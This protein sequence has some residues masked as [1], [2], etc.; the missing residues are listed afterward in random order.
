EG[1]SPAVRSRC[2]DNPRQ[3]HWLEITRRLDTSEID[4]LPPKVRD[5][6]CDL[7]FGILAISAEEHIRWAAGKVRAKHACVADGVEGF[8]HVSARQKPLNL[9]TARV[10]V[11][12]GELRRKSAAAI[13]WVGRVDDDLVP[14]PLRTSCLEGAFVGR[15]EGGEHDDFTEGSGVRKSP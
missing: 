11:S 4:V 5:N 6:A 2:G 7:L 10:R 8:D 3:A 13:E 1:L 14:Q 15:T 12:D 9:L